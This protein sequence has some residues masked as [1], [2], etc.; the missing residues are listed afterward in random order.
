MKKSIAY[1]PKKHQ[2]FNLVE[3]ICKEQIAKYDALA[4]EE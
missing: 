3:R 1:L 4:K 2:L